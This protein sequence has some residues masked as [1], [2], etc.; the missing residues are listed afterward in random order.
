[1]AQAGIL[2]AAGQTGLS[3]IVTSGTTTL[4]T[5]TLSPG[6]NGFSF[7]GMTTGNV[8]VEVVNSAG[9]TVISGTGPIA[10]SHSVFRYFLRTILISEGREH[11]DTLQLQLPGRCV[12]LGFIIQ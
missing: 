9:T 12:S 3:S 8:S 6:F 1:M 10:A 5:Q 2:V 7:L 11:F 4:G